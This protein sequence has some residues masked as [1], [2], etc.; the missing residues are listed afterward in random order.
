[1]I[2]DGS[3]GSPDD[4]YSYDQTREGNSHKG[5]MGLSYTELIAPM[6][7]AIQELSEKVDAQQK[8]IEELKNN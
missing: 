6:I 5:A 3:V 8:E 4:E 1:M 2:R 7:K